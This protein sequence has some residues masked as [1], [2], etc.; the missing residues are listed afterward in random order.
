MS[1]RLLK[2]CLLSAQGT[3]KTKLAKHKQTLIDHT[4]LV[5]VYSYVGDVI[6]TSTRY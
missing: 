2:S 6:P 5:K 1:G 3:D 4:V